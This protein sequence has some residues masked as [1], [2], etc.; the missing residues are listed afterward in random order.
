[1]SYLIEQERKGKKTSWYVCAPVGYYR[2][3]L[4]GRIIRDGTP[5]PEMHERREYAYV[6]PTHRAAA[7]TLSKMGD[8]AKIIPACR[9]D[10]GQGGEIIIDEEIKN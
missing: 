1:M 10:A 7:R 4:S 2:G 3:A 5:S 6:F 8:G 9:W